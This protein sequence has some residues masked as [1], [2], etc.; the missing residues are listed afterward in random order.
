VF[1]NPA[2]RQH[3]RHRSRPPFFT[4]FATF[5]SL[6]EIRE[7]SDPKTLKQK[8]LCSVSSD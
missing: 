8:R 5:C 4:S 3:Y 1:F 2:L 6:F 7:H